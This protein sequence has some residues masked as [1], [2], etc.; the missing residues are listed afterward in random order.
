MKAQKYINYSKNRCEDCKKRITKNRP[1]LYCNLCE[2]TKHFS[3]Q[4]LSRT[5]AEHIIALKLNWTCKNCLHDILP[6]NA[7]KRERNVNGQNIAQNFKVQCTSCTGYCYSVKNIRNCHW[8]EG[9]VHLKCF[10]NDLGCK[11]CCEKN[12]PGFYVTTYEL[13][14]DY[15][16]LNNLIY[17]PYNREHFTNLIGDAIETEEHH[18]SHWSVISEFLVK[19][20]YTQQKNIKSASNCELKLFSLNIRNLLKCIGVIR[21]NIEN[22]N[23]YDILA[24][25][26]TNL[27]IEI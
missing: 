19:C 23:K 14:D 18:N 24:F 27:H 21:N 11:T 25:N 17:N 16:R 4:N 10:N 15:D 1:K 3:C 22:F 9:Q 2:K 8:C 20:K 5:E 6:V 26:E 13:N 7:C 12:I